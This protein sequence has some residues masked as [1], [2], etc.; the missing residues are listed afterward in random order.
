[1]PN[2]HGVGLAEHRTFALHIP[3]PH[4][5]TGHEFMDDRSQIVRRNIERRKR[6]RQLEA[7]WPGAA[8]IDVEH[9]VDRI[10]FRHMRMAGDD[11]VYTAL[12]GVDWQRL[13]IVQYEDRPAR[14]LYELGVRVSAGPIAVVDVPPD[15]SD[16]RDPTQ[17]RDDAGLTNVAAMDD[18]VD[19]SQRTRRFRPQQAVRIRDDADPERSGGR[20]DRGF[21]SGGVD[22]VQRDR[23]DGNGCEIRRNAAIWKGPRCL[24]QDLFIRI[25]S[26]D[27][28]QDELL[29]AVSRRQ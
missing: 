28:C 5:S 13:E 11:D 19:A 25:A 16:R 15:R 14:K 2:H 6:D 23:L 27:V 17:R 7:P 9:I 26:R 29:H 8:G 1:M 21:R 24:R 18:V 12:N 4:S 3:A 20:R 22:V 10:D